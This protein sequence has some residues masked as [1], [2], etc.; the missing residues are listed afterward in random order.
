MHSEADSQRPSALRDPLQFAVALIVCAFTGACGVSPAPATTL[1]EPA[2]PVQVLVEL[3]E[4][5]FELAGTSPQLGD[6]DLA[7]FAA[8]IAG[9]T[10]VGLGE[11]VH[12]V[13][14]YAELRERLIRYLVQ[15]QGFRAVSFEGPWLTAERTR[16]WVEHNE[17]TLG[18]AMGGLN[19]LAWHTEP[20]ARL[21]TWLHDYNLAHPDDPVRVFGGDTQ[22]SGDAAGFIRAALGADAGAGLEACYCGAY[23]SQAACGADPVEAMLL[24]G[25]STGTLSQAR[26]DACLAASQALLGTLAQRHELSDEQRTLTRFA[27]EDLTSYTDASFYY[28][29][30]KPV[31][32]VASFSVRDDGWAAHVQALRALRAPNA[33]TVIWAHNYHLL[34]RPFAATALEG[35]APPE[36]SKLRTLGAG[37]NEAF[38][39][40]Y[41]AFA[42]VAHSETFNDDGKTVTQ[43]RARSKRDDVE[44]VLFGTGRAALFVRLPSS[45][46]QANTTYRSGVDDEA[47]VPADQYDGYFYFAVTS[48]S[49]FYR[50]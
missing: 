15:A 32:L 42:L 49:V 39:G 12:G 7:P 2:L 44:A 17:G 25:K 28:W 38:G 46:Y 30:S 43:G 21:L 5:L 22:S 29:Y 26:R 11:S 10:V 45:G 27:I 1:A 41:A 14:T 4:G 37:L 35:M 34:K 9:K 19:F 8:A 33:K 3:P 31:D 24:V 20:T 18:D 47:Y 36:I 50:R 48:A 40:Q 6:D 13:G 16:A 23:D